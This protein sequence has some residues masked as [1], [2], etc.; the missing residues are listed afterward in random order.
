MFRDAYGVYAR[1][2]HALGDRDAVA[3]VL[4]EIEALAE[5]GR[6]AP[7]ERLIWPVLAKISLAEGD[8]SRAQGW[9]E[10]LAPLSGP[11]VRQ[12]DQLLQARFLLARGAPE[13]AHNLLAPLLNSDEKIAS[14]AI[15]IEAISLEAMATLAQG[16]E[17]GA[18]SSLSRALARGEHEGR[19]RTFADEGEPMRHL[20]EGVRVDVLSNPTASQRDFSVGYIDSLLEAFSAPRESPQPPPAGRSEALSEREA[21]VLHLMDKGLSNQEI[22]DRFVV[23]L[24]T[25]K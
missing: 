2:L 1:I 16:D 7:G 5:Q 20:L 24:S 14:E 9:L 11:D 4:D 8:Q 6:F 12:V 3:E 10:R 19:V 22:A 13:A 15:A 17:E 23:A 18:R 21:E 25:V